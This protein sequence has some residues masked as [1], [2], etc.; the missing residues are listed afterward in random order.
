MKK[1][2]IGIGA[3][4][5]LFGG[6]LVVFIMGFRSKNPQFQ[7]AVRRINRDHFN[8]KAMK[9]AGEAGSNASVVQHI[10]RKSWTPYETPVQAIRLNGEF[11]IPLPYGISADWV[12]NVLAADSAAIIHD[13]TTHKV[14]APKVVEYDEVGHQL[15]YRDQQT[16]RLF[17]VDS[18]LRVTVGID[19]EE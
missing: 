8:P 4:V 12:Q 2:G 16:H 19:E 14:I 11:V 7:G 6:L 9:T 13:G 15:S 3:V 17:G 10:G 1:A 18:F 5:L